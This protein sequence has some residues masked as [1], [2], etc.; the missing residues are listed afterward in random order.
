MDEMKWR[1]DYCW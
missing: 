1:E